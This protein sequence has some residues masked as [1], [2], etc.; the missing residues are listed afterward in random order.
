M[1]IGTKKMILVLAM[2]IIG[3]TSLVAPAPA[4]SATLE[5]SKHN[6]DLGEVVSFTLKNTGATP[7]TAN[8]NLPWW[9]EKLVGGQWVIP[10]SP[11]VTSEGWTLNPN[12]SKT[13]EWNQYTITPITIDAGI[14]KVVVRI[15]GEE[16]YVV[17]TIGDRDSDGM[18]DTVDACPDTAGPAFNNGCPVTTPIK[19][20]TS[21]CVGTTILSIFVLTGLL[22]K[23]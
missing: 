23:K 9:I 6:Y 7:I 11:G 13:W 18:P 5:T 2:L 22:A 12:E 3:L 20:P 17:F 21:S 8:M 15:S 4:A 19:S 14:Y 10:Y 1:K 16:W